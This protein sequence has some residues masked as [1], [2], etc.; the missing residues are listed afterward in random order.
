M[1]FDVNAYLGHFAFRQ[2]RYNTPEALLRLMD[3]K[4][5]ERAAVSAPARSPIATASRE[6]RSCSRRSNP[7]A[8]G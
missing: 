5:I 6:T 4:G 3:S 1:I 7:I 8:T 2:L